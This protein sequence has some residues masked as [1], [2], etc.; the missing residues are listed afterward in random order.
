MHPGHHIE[1]GDRDL[2]AG[3]GFSCIEDLLPQ[4]HHAR[5]QVALSFYSIH[6][7][8]DY[9]WSVINICQPELIEEKHPVVGETR[10]EMSGFA[11]EKWDKAKAVL[12]VFASQGLSRYQMA[13][14][15]ALARVLGFFPTLVTPKI[16]CT[17]AT[18]VFRLNMPL[19]H[20]VNYAVFP[21][22]LA[23][24]VPCRHLTVR[25]KDPGWHRAASGG[26][27]AG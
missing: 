2:D 13:V 23:V 5:P 1:G 17:V 25:K 22:E 16:I 24:L 15:I 8:I 7:G 14:C 4:N 19:I 12:V 20:L 18:F 21:Y 9:G 6:F 27:V 11:S 3:P 10:L 26:I